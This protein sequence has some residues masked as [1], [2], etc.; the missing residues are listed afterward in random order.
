LGNGLAV[1]IVVAAL[2][3]A[4]AVYYSSRFQNAEDFTVL[5]DSE[6]RI[7]GL[8]VRRNVHS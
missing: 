2:A 4:A 1:A 7:T 3:I 6:G 8:E 5:R